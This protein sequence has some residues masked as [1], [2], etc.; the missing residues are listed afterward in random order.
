MDVGENIAVR[1]P[2]LDRPGLF[3]ADR[4]LGQSA[5]ILAL[6]KM[7]LIAEAVADDRDIEIFGCILRRAGAQAVQAQ[8]VFIGVAAV[9]VVFAAGIEFAVDQFPVVALFLAD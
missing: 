1:P 2:F 8:A 9:V 5:D 4:L 6:F 3:L 7:Q